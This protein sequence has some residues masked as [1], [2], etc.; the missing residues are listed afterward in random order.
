MFKKP[1]VFITNIV[2]ILLLLT[3]LFC[4]GLLYK[5]KINHEKVPVIFGLT[6]ISIL[7]GSMRPY[8]D[9]G[10]MVVINTRL[11][12]IKVGDVIVFSKNNLL[13]THR[14]VGID[15][16]E[17]VL[18]YKTKGDDNNTPDENIVYKEQL[19]GGVILKIPFGGYIADKISSRIGFALFIIVPLML[20]IGGEL[21]ELL[22]K[23]KA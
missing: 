23:T 13:I 11:K 16:R 19:I 17:G 20:L 18:V 7:T 8:L 22:H 5:S 2:L 1:I 14:I 12:D 4:I 3:G 10:D 21:K 6:P 9:P 15:N